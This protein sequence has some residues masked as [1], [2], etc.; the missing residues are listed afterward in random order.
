M[1]DP[2]QLGKSKVLLHEVNYNLGNFYCILHVHTFCQHG[3]Q[4]KFKVGAIVNVKCSAL[5]H[6]EAERYVVSPVNEAIPVPFSF[7]PYYIRNGNNMIILL[8][9]IV[10]YYRKFRRLNLGCK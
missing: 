8:T 2:Y 5:T 9:Y 4:F 3:H 7:S 1:L 10:G 6:S